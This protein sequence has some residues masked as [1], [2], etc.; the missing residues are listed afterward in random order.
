MSEPNPPRRPLA[1]FLRTTPEGEAAPAT[2]T[3]TQDEAGPA[4]SA[5][6]AP[7][8]PVDLAPAPAAERQHDDDTVIVDDTAA[9][10][11][12]PVALP[13]TTV[14][15]DAP[16]FLGNARPRALPTP[17]WHWAL[18]AALALLL[19]LQS[20]LAD[21]ARLA[22]DAG[23]RAWLGTLCGVLRCSLPAWHEPTAFTMTSRE[24]RPLPGQ[25]GVLQVQ[26]S[27]R[28][29]ARWAQAWPDLRL[30]LS[31]AD[32]RVIGS[33]VFTPAQYLGEN[34]GA[35]LLEPGQ[36]ARVAFR[37]QEPAASTVAFTFDFL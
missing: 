14:A 16:S 5:T 3:R 30:S 1:T 17:R 31:D 25:A 29:D 36:S 20:V 13:A 22:A 33:G 26:A 10:E 9:I 2:D 37:V 24:I 15:A 27:I 8:A 19:V 32:G 6:Q 7:A 34:P 28:N 35:A 23:N 4:A 11:P 18:V 21:R 12:A